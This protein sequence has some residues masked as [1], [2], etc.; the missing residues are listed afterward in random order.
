VCEAFGYIVIEAAAGF[1]LGASILFP[2]TF[3]RLNS[4]KI[5]FKNSFK[6]LLSTMPFTIAA[7]ILEGFVTRY[8]LQMP[9]ALGIFIILFT[10][11]LISFYYLVYP[12]IVF[13]KSKV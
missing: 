8:A 11:S 9:K 1:I 10:L 13:K 3:S 6:I 12:Y 2:N 4:L 7:G 5:G